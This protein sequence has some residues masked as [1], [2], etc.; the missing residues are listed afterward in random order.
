MRGLRLLLY[1]GLVA[2]SPA[3]ALTLTNCGQQWLF[4]KVPQRTLV[5]THSALEN[6]LALGAGP[7]IMAVVGYRPDQDTAPSPWTS[8]AR[9]TARYD[10]APWS[11]EALLAAR[12][13][14]IYSASYYWFNSPETPDRR[15]LARWGIATWLAASDCQG[16]QSQSARPLTYDDIFSEFRHVAAIYHASPRAEQVITGLEKQLTA[17]RR[18]AQH[19]PALRMMWWYS[20]LNIPYVA[21]GY[22]APALLT[23]TVGSSN[24]F[25]A[26]R[27]RWPAVS[28][29][30]IAA[31]QPDVLVLG[32]LRRGAPGD[33]AADKI[34]FLE[35]NP[36]TAGMQAV[37]QR[38][39]IILP[40]YDMDPSVRTV[41]ALG[42][43]ITQ[44]DTLHTEDN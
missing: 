32:D 4:D 11:G 19:L 16:Q 18:A 43:L 34:A 29:E 21:G 5:Y 27:E 17:S 30:V 20:G 23:R 36:L 12:P 7:A 3:R 42:R 37:R 14:F 10:P 1:I 40:G 41:L 9:L 24:I 35:R 39:Y 33:S 25:A 6:L 2:A 8:A 26:I 44:L 38:R 31:R 13:D 28:W 15:R 22:G